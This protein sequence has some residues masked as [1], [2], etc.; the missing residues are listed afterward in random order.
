M[1]VNW[2]IILQNIVSDNEGVLGIAVIEMNSRKL[3]DSAQ[4]I[5]HLSPS[6]LEAIAVS[7]VEVIRGKAVS[8]I[9]SLLST[10]LN[11]PLKNS[12]DNVCINTKAT[13][14]FLATV[15]NKPDFLIILSTNKI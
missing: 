3:V 15:Q 4:T 5:G 12:I 8:A 2:R 9:E 1:S 11:T 7:A 13:R 10:H 14:I 6:M